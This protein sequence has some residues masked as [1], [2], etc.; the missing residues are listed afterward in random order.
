M[1][2]N[3]IQTDKKWLRVGVIVSA[4]LFEVIGMGGFFLNTEVNAI[5][6]QQA[7]LVMDEKNDNKTDAQFDKRLALI[8]A[9][10][11]DREAH[12]HYPHIPGSMCVCIFGN[13]TLE[14]GK[15][16]VCEFGE[17]C[18]QNAI[19]GCQTIHKGASCQPLF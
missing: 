1:D 14:K 17:S 15:A 19:I 2:D 7:Q 18:D 6:Q 12:K 3:K 5:G 4:L 9:K 16:E 8:E 10:L 11:A 13:N